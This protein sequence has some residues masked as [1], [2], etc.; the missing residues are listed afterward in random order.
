MG[1]FRK[2]AKDYLLEGTDQSLR[3]EYGRAIEN[4]SK[5][6]E[7]D[8][9]NATAYLHRG[10]AFLESGQVEQ[11]LQDFTASLQREQSAFCYYNRAL[12]WMAK[13]D[14]ERSLRD[15]DEAVRLSPEDA[16]N[17]NLRAIVHSGLGDQERAIADIERAIA[18]GRRSGWMSKAIFLEKAGRDEEAL[19]SWGRALEV[20]PKDA[21]ALCRRGLLLLRLGRKQEAQRDL[22]QAWKKR[23][24]LEEH[25]RVE[26]EQ[27]LQRLK[28]ETMG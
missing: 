19:E 9:D 8:P 17:Y 21:L 10:I 15:L 16:E 7:L 11:A 14:L 12:A 1:W 26:I 20:D 22:E 3:R 25:W 28:D 2:T 23:K 6:L 18:L 4:L 24:V 5:A 27:A 13:K